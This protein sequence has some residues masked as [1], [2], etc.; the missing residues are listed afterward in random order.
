MIRLS[1]ITFLGTFLIVSAMARGSQQ[2]P[3][4]EPQRTNATATVPPV[5][6]ILD[7]YVQAIGGKAAVE[8]L[9]TRVMKGLLI[10]P[11]GSAPIEIYEKAPNKFLII[12]NSP[13]SG[14]S[15]N[16]FDGSVAW[17]QNPQRGLREMS[18]P[19]VENFKREYNLHREIKLKELYP[20]MMVKRREK[21]GEQEAYLVEAITTDGISEAM[22]FDVG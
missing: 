18:G 3:N 20:K 1:I 7:R 11:G 12:I 22:Y 9:K 5:D 17:S 19:D 4:A 10:A 15:Q 2:N 6:Q 8:K 21:I 14:I 13:A 16:G